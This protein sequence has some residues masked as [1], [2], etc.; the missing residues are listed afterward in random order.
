MSEMEPEV[1][2]F[3]S[4]IM[5]SISMTFLWLLINSTIGIGFNYAF[6]DEKPNAGNY[7]FYAW[8][9]V[10]FFFLVKYLLKKW[11]FSKKD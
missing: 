6:F 5:S 8:F 2:N 9:L 11:D 10:S 4:K 3:L 1:K 7:V